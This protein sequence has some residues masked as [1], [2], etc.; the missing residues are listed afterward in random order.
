VKG[1]LYVCHGT[2]GSPD[3]PRNALRLRRMGFL[4]SRVGRT[5]AQRRAASWMRFAPEPNLWGQ[6]PRNQPSLRSLRLCVRKSV[7]TH[8]MDAAG[9]HP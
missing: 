5:P 7:W 6:A 8:P 1:A 9:T 4:A 3:E 2:N